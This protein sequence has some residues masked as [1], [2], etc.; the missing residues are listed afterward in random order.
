MRSGEGPYRDYDYL[1]G[2]LL[3]LARE[4]RNVRK[5]YNKSFSP[6]HSRNEIIAAKDH[7]LG[8]LHDFERRSGADLAG[9]AA[10]RR[11]TATLVPP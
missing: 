6:E 9:Y 3:A 10:Y 11:D 4:L 7:L 8:A 2:L 5:G 1:E